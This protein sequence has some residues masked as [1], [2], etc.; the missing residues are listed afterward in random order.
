MRVIILFFLLIFFSCDT[1]PQ[2]SAIEI[3][4]IGENEWMMNDLNKVDSLG[5]K[6]DFFTYNEALNACPE[7]WHL[8]TINEWNNLKNNLQNID[9]NLFFSS[10]KGIE[11]NDTTTSF[12]GKVTYYWARSSE[13]HT[14]FFKSQSESL[15]RFSS[16]DEN[17][18]LCVKCVKD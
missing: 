14:Y 4:K 18:S 15:L 6:V 3:F 10:Y 1:T 7:G 9:V 13:P 12:A 5:N 17:Y 11:I 8:P 2:K 16:F